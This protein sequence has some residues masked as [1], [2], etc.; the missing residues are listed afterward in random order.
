MKIVVIK[1]ISEKEL[2]TINSIKNINILV[3]AKS[4]TRDLNVKEVKDIFI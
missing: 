4:N 1:Y 2:S 3:R